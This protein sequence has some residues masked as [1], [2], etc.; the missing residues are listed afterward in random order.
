LLVAV[1]AS[2]PSR[3]STLLPSWVSFSGYSEDYSAVRS[4]VNS[5]QG[6][7]SSSSSFGPHGSTRGRFSSSAY[8]F[9][10]ALCHQGCE[11]SIGNESDWAESPLDDILLSPISLPVDRFTLSPIEPG[12]DYLK[13]RDLILYWLQS[14]GFSTARAD[15]LLIINI[16]NS[17][18]S[19]FWEGH[20]CT[21]LKD[22]LVR[23]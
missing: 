10:S 8:S 21:A 3:R 5:Y 12:K 1:S 17:L 19:Q 11:S 9:P 7:C 2:H 16:W 18:A 22:G 14:P 20:L 6:E 15:S 23:H 13:S 4:L